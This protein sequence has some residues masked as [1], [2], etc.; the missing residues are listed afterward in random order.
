M[1]THASAPGHVTNSA[2]DFSDGGRGPTGW[3]GYTAPSAFSGGAGVQQSGGG[4]YQQHGYTAPMGLDA[5]PPG[6]HGHL[7]S[8]DKWTDAPLPRGDRGCEE[9]VNEVDEKFAVL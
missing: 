1:Q 5:V 7:P 6:V 8:F 3:C 4:Q 9:N 2:A